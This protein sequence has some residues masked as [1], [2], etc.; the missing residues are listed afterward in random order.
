MVIEVQEHFYDDDPSQGH[1]DVKTRLKDTSYF[2]LGNGYIQAAV[3]V[4]P[5]G[6]GTPVG[7]LLMNPE[8]LAKKREALTMHPESGLENTMLR[9]IS[10]RLVSAPTA[11]SV[12]AS[13]F[14]DYGIPAVQVEWINK[15]FQ[16]VEFFYC[17][18]L[19]CPLLVREVL[20]TSRLNSKVKASLQTGSTQDTINQEFFLG[21]KKER[22]LFLQYQLERSGKRVLL[23][24][25]LE[26]KVKQETIEYWKN[27]AQ[28]SFSSPLL[29]HFFN[30]SRFQLPSVIS[31][32]GKVDGSVWQY[33]RE[34]VRDQ[35]MMSVGLTLS[36]HHEIA[37]R[38][39]QRLLKEFV[40]DEG[41]TVDSSEKRESDEVELDQN[42]V[43]LYALKHYVLWAGDQEL[44]TENWNKIISTAEFPLTSVFRHE[45]SGLLANRRE[46]WERHRVHGIETGMELMSQLFV[47][48]GL[49]S[50]AVL[51]RLVSRESEA[52]RWEKEAGKIRSAMLNP[53]YGLVDNR[54]FIKRRGVDGS[55]QESVRALSE[56]RLPEEV[57]LSGE[58]IHFLNPD[59]SAALPIAMEFISPDSSIGLRTMDNFET[60]WNQEWDGGGYG[61][62]HASSE[63]DSPGAWPFPSLFIA[64]AYVEMENFDKV[65]RIFQ[66]LN[67]IPGAKA[68]SWFEFYGKRLAPPFPQVG[69]TPWTWA[70][71]LILLVHHIV[72]VQPGEKHLRIR[73]KLL[74]GIEEINA[75]LPFKDGRIKLEI[76][77]R[78]KERQTVFRSNGKIIES[79]AKQAILA[80]SEKEL[81]IEALLA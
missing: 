28:V 7:L 19:S 66:W 17:P 5:S 35:A 31:S 48:V 26:I 21:S 24:F 36:G 75:V 12:K 38:M 52:I 25:A 20:I 44:I 47:S 2:F 1:P 42:G 22:R 60:L 16:V 4:A 45:S 6:E 69:I 51:A 58:E 30:A 18:D 27:K 43:L 46:Y 64:R 10:E 74:P 78:Q 39:L 56:A 41:D 8:R 14:N 40:T 81:W 70:E 68:G 11:E 71:M 50:A 53:R 55:I 79:S 3:Q 49:S 72:G 67:T 54:G 63:P 37:R 13:W 65:W 15:G 23:D 77:R 76:K 9:I 73:P 57:P 59:A 29:D 32:S 61:R 33:N 62:Y 80:Y 34:W